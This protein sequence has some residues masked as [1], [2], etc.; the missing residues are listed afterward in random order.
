MIKIQEPS[1]PWEIFHM[2]CVTGLPPGGNRSYNSFPV[3]VDRFSKTP[4][5]FPRQRDDTAVDTALLIWNRVVS[6]TGIIT[7]ITVTGIQNSPQHYGQTFTNFWNK[8]F[9]LYSLPPTN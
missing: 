8:C 1:R 4:S 7:N 9:L 3:I 6:C 2:D 5:F